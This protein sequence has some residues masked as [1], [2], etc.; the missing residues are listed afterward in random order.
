MLEWN[1][2]EI[3]QKMQDY[4]KENV[5][6]DGFNLNNLYS[7][8]GYSP[9]HCERMFKE[10]LGKTSQE[11]IRLIIISESSKRLI[12]SNKKI[13]DIAL[14]SSFETHE[15]YTR[16]FYNIFGITP[17][18]YRK[19]KKPIPLFVQYSI[20]SYYSYFLEKG[21][22]VMNK[23]INLC[24]ITTVERPKRKLIFLRS[25][26]ATEYFSYCEE[27]GCEW[28]GLF[29]SIP[30]KIEDAAILE[31]PKFLI[32][33]GFSNIASGVEVPLDYNN[34]IPKNCEITELEEC[35]MLFFES[36]AFEKEEDFFPACESVFK[37]VEK[38]EPIKYGFKYAD[39]MAPRFNF[40][41]TTTVRYAVPVKQIQLPK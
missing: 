8:I 41:G 18:Q 31:L 26:K 38:Y 5:F 15:G 39:E 27:M 10:L 30:T 23:E 35:K 9:R 7:Y 20:K 17:N 12:K 11:Y 34:D 37:A 13:L 4:I 6:K 29:N 2:I 33:E 3:V 1:K 32:K 24:M 16:A 22:K 19:T 14:E 36:E 28:E 25:K 40:G 21:D